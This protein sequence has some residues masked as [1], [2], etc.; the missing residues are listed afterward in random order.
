MKTTIR[1]VI[2][3]FAQGEQMVLDK[4]MGDYSAAVRWAYKRLL[5]GT[6][7]QK[8]R[9]MVQGKFLSNSR[10][11]NDAVYEAQATIS[12]QRELLKLNH[13]NAVAKVESIQK[14]LNKAKNPHKIENLTRKLDKWQRKLAYWQKFLETNTLPPVVFGTKELFH[15]RCKGLISKEEWK[16][17]RSNRYVSRGD[18]TKGGNLNARLSLKDDQLYLDIVTEAVKTEKSVRFNRMTAPV[19]LAQKRSKKTGVVNGRNYRQMMMDYLKTGKAYQV[20]IIRENN[21]YYVHVTIEEKEAESYSSTKGIIGVDT[22]PDGLGVAEVDYLGQYR[23]SYFLRQ[24][25]WTYARSNRRL[26]LMGEMAKEIVSRAKSKGKGLAVEDLKFR[27]DKSVSVKF[28][29]ITHGFVW[30]K[31]LQ[32]VERRALREGVPLVKVKPPYTSVIGIL[33]Y[34]SQYG[35]SNHQA[36]SYI[37]G[38]RALGYSEENVP[39]KFLKF[40]TTKELESFSKQTNWKQWS[41]VQKRVTKTINIIKRKEVKSLVSWQHI[42]KECLAKVTPA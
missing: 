26:N 42:R 24:G 33:K 20:E 8:L 40:L 18:S 3:S 27:D 6:E 4:L 19:Y 30:S 21:R 36:A 15:R 25:E 17:A 38:R 10:Q 29:R 39:V 37:I 35:F 28:N 14:K 23:G 22:N 2:L 12:S 1:G 32:C 9:I 11:A 41:I 34:Q 16:Q 7:V 5:E 31:F 13:E